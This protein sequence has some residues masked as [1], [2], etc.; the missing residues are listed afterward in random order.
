MKKKVDGFWQYMNK[1]SSK[2]K[3]FFVPTPGAFYRY[4]PDMK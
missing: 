1:T 3:I 4:L 2:K